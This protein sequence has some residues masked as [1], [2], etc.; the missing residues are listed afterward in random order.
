MSSASLFCALITLFS[1]T[2]LST[3]CPKVEIFLKENNNFNVCVVFCLFWIFAQWICYFMHRVNWN[4]QTNAYL[5]WHLGSIT[6]VSPSSVPVCLPLF[7]VLPFWAEHP[8]SPLPLASY[9]PRCKIVN[10]HFKLKFTA[11]TTLGQFYQKQDGELSDNQ[12][13]PITDSPTEQPTSTATHCF[14]SAKM[15]EYNILKNIWTFENPAALSKLDT[16]NK[17]NREIVKTPRHYSHSF[18]GNRKNL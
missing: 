12:S 8:T 4:C 5:V 1:I 13:I 14:L 3:L 18:V 9:L 10:K 6:L 17:V 11:R 15:W 16:G 2:Q 7:T